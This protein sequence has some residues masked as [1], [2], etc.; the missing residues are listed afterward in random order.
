MF[1]F[2]FNLLLEELR[3][4]ENSEKREVIEK[5]EKNFWPISGS[6]QDQ[7]RYK[8]Y[9]SN[10]PVVEYIVPFASKDDFDWGLLCQLSAASFS[11]EVGLNW[12]EEN[13]EAE[14]IIS[15]E[16]GG[17]VIAKKVSELFGYQIDRLF[18]I[19]CEEQMNLQNHIHEN[20]QEKEEILAQRDYKLRQWK[21]RIDHLSTK[22]EQEK[23]QAER[24]DKLGNLMDQL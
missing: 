16:N 18:K 6:V 19:Y 7:K 13:T 20:E 9:V 14:Y 15:V 24:S 10:F 1:L 4:H 17:Q 5:Y 8:E 22:K 11:S 2:D 3:N 21:L 12:N 23:E